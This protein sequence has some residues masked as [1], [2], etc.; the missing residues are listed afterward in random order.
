MWKIA[1]GSSEERTESESQDSD[2]V[3][4]WTFEHLNIW[5]FE[6]LHSGDWASWT[7]TQINL[8][9]RLWRSAYLLVHRHL[10][11]FNLNCAQQILAQS[12]ETIRAKFILEA[13]INFGQ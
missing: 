6:H 9:E 13:N 3:N 11:V 10:K 1:Q 2:G 8:G 4:I 12:I 5:T 7:V